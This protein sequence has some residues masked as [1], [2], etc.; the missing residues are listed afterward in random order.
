MSKKIG[1]SEA[2]AWGA[3]K[4]AQQYP[5]KLHTLKLNSCFLRMQ[6]DLGPLKRQLF[7]NAAIRVG[8][9]PNR[10]VILQ[11]VW[12]GVVVHA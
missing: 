12:L 7:W 10:L 9:N 4:M 3:S 1:T 8:P 11:E 2:F 5:P 6:I